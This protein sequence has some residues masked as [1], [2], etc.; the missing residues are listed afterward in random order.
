M[1]FG[2]RKR[3]GPNLNTYEDYYRWSLSKE[4][5]WNFRSPLLSSFWPDRVSRNNV[6]MSVGV[7][8]RSSSVSVIRNAVS[9]IFHIV[10]FFFTFAVRKWWPT[11]VRGDHRLYVVINV[12]AWWSPF[13]RGDQLRTWWQR[14]GVPSQWFST[15]LKFTEFFCLIPPVGD[16]QNA[17]AIRRFWCVVLCHALASCFPPS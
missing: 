4:T 1:V 2:I 7:R 12:H 3:P 11:F 5:F 6:I 15:S 9:V 17:V 14:D 16:V 10:V 13:V 8:S